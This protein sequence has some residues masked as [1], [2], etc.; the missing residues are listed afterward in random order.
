MDFT[1]LKSFMDNLNSWRIPAIRFL[2][3]WTVKRC[4]T[5]GQAMPT[6][7]LIRRKAII[8]RD[9]AMFL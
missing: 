7:C 5:T 3:I 1:H 8:S 4:L 6:I 9:F 2:F